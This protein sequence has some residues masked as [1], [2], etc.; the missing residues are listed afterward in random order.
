VKNTRIDCEFLHKG[1]AMRKFGLAGL[2]MILVVLFLSAC[3]ADNHGGLSAA[4][5]AE[6]ANAVTSVTAAPPP[7]AG[8]CLACH[9][10]KDRLIDTA[11]PLEEAGETESKGVG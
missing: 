11:A 6:M 10:D 4:E 5:D 7:Q 9:T 1:D 2:F 3:D 8:E